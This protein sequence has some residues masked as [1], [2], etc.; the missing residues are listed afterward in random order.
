MKHIPHWVIDALMSKK[1]KCHNCKIAFTSKNLTALGIRDSF[2]EQDKETFF[3]ELICKQCSKST[4]FE[5]QEMNI[6]ELSKEV[7]RELSVSFE[8]TEEINMLPDKEEMV[9]EGKPS[10]KKSKNSKITLKDIRESVKVLSPKD[11]KHE[12]F[13]EMLGMP[14]EE[15][16]EY[17]GV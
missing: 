11:L 7:I 16:M 13:L 2:G 4:F 1:F 15:I 3:M 12:S 6:V 14:P 17:R 9:H 10:L 5:M 8:E